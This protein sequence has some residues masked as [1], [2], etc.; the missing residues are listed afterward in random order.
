MARNVSQLTG[1]KVTILDPRYTPS[2]GIKKFTLLDL[3]ENAGQTFNYEIPLHEQFDDITDGTLGETLDRDRSKFFVVYETGD[4]TTAAEGEPTPLDL[5]YSQA[6]QYG[7]LY[8]W[9]DVADGAWT[10]HE[11]LTYGTSLDDDYR[12]PWLEKDQEDLSGEAALTASP[13]GDFLYAD[14]SQWREDE[15]ENIFDSDIWFR[16]LFYSD[17]DT[18][19][20][21]IIQ[22]PP[23][24]A[25][26]DTD[27]E[28]VLNA[29]A[30]DFDQFGEG[31][32]IVEYE[33]SVDSN[34]RTDI[35]GS[36]FN[37]PPRTLSNG[38]HTFSVRAKDNDG[39][40]SKPAYVRVL[41]VDEIHT[42]FLPLMKR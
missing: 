2:G 30:V 25:M 38:W 15:Y 11:D 33:W 39:K 20:Q 37:A 29:L 36:R 6:T 3:Y 17:V 16:R 14:W 32:D 18:L 4:N 26:F 7:D 27:Q 19:P 9:Y 5:F 35:S 41:I 1:T 40:W 34:I 21:L 31:S 24:A 28:F 22:D 13:S 8:E 23:L 10:Q 42:I 12:W